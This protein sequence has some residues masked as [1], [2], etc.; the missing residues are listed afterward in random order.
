V[1]SLARTN[2][3]LTVE[4]PA[5]I[6]I[7]RLAGG[8]TLNGEA[9]DVNDPNAAEGIWAVTRNGRRAVLEMAP[10]LRLNDQTVASGALV[11]DHLFVGVNAVAAPDAALPDFARTGAES[12]LRGVA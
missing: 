8:W 1:Q 4:D 10:G 11:A 12:Q 5:G 2:F 7:R 3:G 6:A 9:V